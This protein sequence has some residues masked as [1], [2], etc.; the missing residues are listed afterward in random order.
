MTRD[1]FTPFPGVNPVITPSK[2]YD[3]LGFDPNGN[4]LVFDAGKQD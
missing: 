3:K 4:K 1:G 2:H